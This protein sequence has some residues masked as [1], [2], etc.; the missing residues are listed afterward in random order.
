MRGQYELL[1]EAGLV[2]QQG[3]QKSDGRTANSKVVVF[4]N[5]QSRLDIRLILK[6]SNLRISFFVVIISVPKAIFDVDVDP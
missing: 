6:L 4:Q 3:C 1:H 2:D 5:V